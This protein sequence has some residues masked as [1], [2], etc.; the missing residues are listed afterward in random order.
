MET[1]QATTERFAIGKHPLR[2][3]REAFA[4]PVQLRLTSRGLLGSSAFRRLPWGKRAF[5]VLRQK[6]VGSACFRT[7]SRSIR[8][9]VKETMQRVERPTAMLVGIAEDLAT[10][11]GDAL[12][13]G[14]LKV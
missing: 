13:E 10:L 7:G 4:A 9:S 12:Q 1:S 2:F 11:C 3:W 5:A 14:G 6:S 8:D